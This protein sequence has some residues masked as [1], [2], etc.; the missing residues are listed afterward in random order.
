LRRAAA[1][2]AIEPI[3]T[4]ATEEMNERNSPSTSAGVVKPIA[5]EGV[6]VDFVYRNE[7]N[8]WAVALLRVDGDSSVVTA[9][10]H[11]T[12]VRSGE[13]LR[14]SGQWVQHA[15]FGEQFRVD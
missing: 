10:G 7:E 8:A 5:I 11:L 2:V 14:A 3:Q 6:I 12:G 9:V 13:R 1:K 4:P 15:R